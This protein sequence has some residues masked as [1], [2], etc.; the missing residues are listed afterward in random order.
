MYRTGK[1]PSDEV[2]NAQRVGIYTVAGLAEI[3]CHPVSFKFE[4][5]ESLTKTVSVV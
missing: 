1:S 2:Y 5:R 3:V 4:R